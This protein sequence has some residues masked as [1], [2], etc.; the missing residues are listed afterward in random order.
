[1]SIKLITELVLN[2]KI[3]FVFDCLPHLYPNVC[4]DIGAAAGKVALQMLE[5][6]CKKIYCFEPFPGNWEFWYKNM[7]NHPEAIL[8]RYAL[9]DKVGFETFLIP[10]TVSGSEPGWE[11]YKGYSSVGYLESVSTNSQATAIKVPVTTLDEEFI[12]QKISFC[13]IDTQGAELRVLMGAELLLGKHL[14]DML[15]MEWSGDTATCEYLLNKGYMIYDSIYTAVAKQESFAPFLDY[16][17]EFLSFGNLSTGKKAFNMRLKTGDP[18]EA[19]RKVKEDNLVEWIQTDLI[20]VT[21][22]ISKLLEIS[23]N[24]M[25]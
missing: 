8:Y 25:S 12:G 19:M 6:G 10:S 20:A 17:F 16:G 2:P 5:S 9:A 18:I 13:K 24:K 21:P 4:L 15:Y 3:D 23:L 14:I 7:Q 11:D 22:S 1:M